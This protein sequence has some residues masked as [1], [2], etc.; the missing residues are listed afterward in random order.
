MMKRFAMLACAGLLVVICSSQALAWGGGYRHW[1]NCKK[2]PCPED[3]RLQRFWHDY[4]KSLSGFYCS[5]DHM[6]WVAYYKNH[7]TPAPSCGDCNNQRI[8]YM[9]VVVTPGMQYLIPQ[10]S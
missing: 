3:Q 2:C 10:G 8:H 6:D 9:P 1:C 7:G 5:L 4:Y